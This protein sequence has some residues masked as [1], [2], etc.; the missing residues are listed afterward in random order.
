MKIEVSEFDLKF[1]WGILVTAFFCGILQLFF[2]QSLINAAFIICMAGVVGY[3]TNFLAIRMLFQPKQGKVLGWEGLVPKNKPQIA[4]S[5]ADNVQNRLLSPEIILDYIHEQHLLEV[6]TQ[7]V[8]NWVDKLI[9]DESIRSKMTSKITDLLSEK[10][11]SLLE[12]VFNFSD[13]MII[14]M[15][16]NPEEIT[17]HWTV[18]R[19]Q[20][21]DYI[22]TQENR[23]HVAD[24]I[25]TVIE[26]EIPK[27]VAL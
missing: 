1:R 13:E 23:Q 5:L 18:F 4:E 19:I 26:K 17:K 2:T 27:I 10:G 20:I 7:K 22:K 9:E 11:A 15:A 21:V 6:G 12:E 3:Y 25:K 8:I 14:N 16:Q 24:L